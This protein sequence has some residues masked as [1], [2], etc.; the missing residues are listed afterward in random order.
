MPATG[1]QI[2]PFVQDQRHGCARGDVV[3]GQEAS[4]HGLDG[5]SKMTQD[6]PDGGVEGVAATHTTILAQD[7]GWSSLANADF[8]HLSAER[9]CVGRDV[10]QGGK[11]VGPSV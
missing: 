5:H 11:S 7:A 10:R 9:G 2:P 3:T 6:L 8:I 1:D 4:R